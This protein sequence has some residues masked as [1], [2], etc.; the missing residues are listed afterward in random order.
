VGTPT[1]EGAVGFTNDP[2]DAGSADTVRVGEL[3][4][5]V[6]EGEAGDDAARFEP[7]WVR[8]STSANT[9]SAAA[10]PYHRYRRRGS[11]GAAPSSGHPIILGLQCGDLPDIE[12]FALSSRL[13][14]LR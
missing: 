5:L 7:C 12:K 1:E 14:R 3:D 10:A 4:V 11:R 8:V 6:G 2:D 13:I 9:T